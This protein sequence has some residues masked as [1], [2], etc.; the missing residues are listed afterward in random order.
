MIHFSI[1][2]STHS[3]SLVQ[4]RRHLSIII[5]SVV[6]DGVVVVIVVLVVGLTVGFVVTIT[7][8]RG[9]VTISS[10]Q[11]RTGPPAMLLTSV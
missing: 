9:R 2:K 10:T 8:G 5:I 4:T 6:V 7:G 1:A 3:Y 11:E